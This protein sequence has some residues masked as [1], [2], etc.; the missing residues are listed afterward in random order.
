MKK[1]ETPP[2]FNESGE[3]L[4]V[5]DKKLMLSCLI[6]SVAGITFNRTPYAEF[7]NKAIRKRT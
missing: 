5:A 1:G 4:L 3:S 7:G 2:L 6:F